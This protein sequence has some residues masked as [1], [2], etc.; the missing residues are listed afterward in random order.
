MAATCFITHA[1]R[2]HIDRTAL[3][4]LLNEHLEID[5]ENTGDT[6]A[7]NPHPTS[8]DPNSNE[9][10]SVEGVRSV[11]ERQIDRASVVMALGAMFLQH[12]HRSWAEYELAYATKSGKPVIAFTPYGTSDLHPCLREQADKVIVSTRSDGLVW[13]PSDVEIALDML[14]ESAHRTECTK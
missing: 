13:S 5:I 3:L 1:G 2:E 8:L 11:L 6:E 12:D 14:L 9:L 4:R 7:I 10:P